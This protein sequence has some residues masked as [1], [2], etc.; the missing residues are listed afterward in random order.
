MRQHGDVLQQVA[1][2]IAE[3]HGG[4]RHP[5]K[6][7]GLIGWPTVEVERRDARLIEYAWCGDHIDEAGAKRRVHCH[8]LWSGP[9]LPQ[10]Q[11]RVAGSANPEERRMTRRL[12]MGQSKADDVTVERDRAFKVGD[13]QVHFEQIL[14]G[15]H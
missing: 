15:S 1:V 10:S 2:W 3:E 11:H 6:N 4:G 8:G 12:D 14:N 7:S 13:R 9:C 5:G